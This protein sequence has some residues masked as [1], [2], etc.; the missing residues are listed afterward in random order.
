MFET[1]RKKGEVRFNMFHSSNVSLPKLRAK[2]LLRKRN[3]IFSIF[4][5]IGNTYGNYSL[6]VVV[7]LNHLGRRCSLLL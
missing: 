5:A 3:L 4:T 2:T 7:F 6:Y 1:L